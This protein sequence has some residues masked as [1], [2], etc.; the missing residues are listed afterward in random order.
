[1]QEIIPLISS[2]TEGPLGLKHLPRLWAK[3]LLSAHKRLPTGYKDVKPGFDFMILEGLGIDPEKVHDYIFSA[4]PS[5]L[6]FENWLCAQPETDS[7]PENIDRINKIVTD[8]KKAPSSREKMLKANNL[9]LDSPIDSSIMMNNLD[10][11]RELYL[12]LG[13]TSE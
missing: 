13:S 8:R 6:Q 12:S 10:D 4:K 3:T 2:G 1:M 7:S 9:P 5:Y 11:W